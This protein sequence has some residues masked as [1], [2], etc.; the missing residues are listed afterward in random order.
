MLFLISLIIGYLFGKI[1]CNFAYKLQKKIKR[2]TPFKKVH[3]HHSLI[4]LLAALIGISLL[5]SYTGL[6]T[7]GFGM[8]LFLHHLHTEGS[9]L[10]SLE[11]S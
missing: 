5:P 10:I 3:I 1:F 9:T 2:K 4:G 6:F 8:G 11:K 7:T